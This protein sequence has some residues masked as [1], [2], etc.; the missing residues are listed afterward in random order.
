MLMNIMVVD[1]DAIAAQR[2]SARTADLNDAHHLVFPLPSQK[3][4]KDE[5]R[6]GVFLVEVKALSDKTRN[7]L[8]LGREGVR[9]KG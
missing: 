8:Y 2:A 7:G 3:K 5:S 6:A 1:A 9:V 4:K